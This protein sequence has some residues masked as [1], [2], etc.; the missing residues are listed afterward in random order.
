MWAIG[1]PTIA[2]GLRKSNGQPV[3]GSLHLSEAFAKET[4]AAILLVGPRP[5]PGALIG[6]QRI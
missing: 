3:D 5:R 4:G 1:F 6:N 2:P